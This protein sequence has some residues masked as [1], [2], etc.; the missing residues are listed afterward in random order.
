MRDGV[1]RPLR[2][3]AD[4]GKARLGRERRARVDHRHLVAG[5]RDELG[6]HL[7][8]VGGAD[9]QDARA[10]HQRM[11]E[12]LALGR[13]GE[14]A[15]AGLEALADGLVG[16]GVLALEHLAAGI[17]QTGAHDQAVAP[18]AGLDGAAEQGQSALLLQ[19][20]EEDLDLAAAGQA[21]PPGGLVL[22][23]EGERLGLAV[24]QDALG[25]GDHLAFDAAARHRP[26]EAPVGGDHHLPADPHRR[27]APG[28]D[29]RGQRDA[30]VLVEPLCAPHRERRG[31]LPCGWAVQVLSSLS[32]RAVVRSDAAKPAPSD[33]FV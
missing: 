25:L 17:R 23:A 32:A 15:L 1:L 4:A 10:R 20:L 30:A 28:A 5:Q 16:L 13:L 18:G 2:V 7:A 12:D 24:G 31:Y 22:D 21:D 14:L 26:L 8:D 19:P 9:H 29:H 6:Q 11:Q 3:E 33:A 27:R